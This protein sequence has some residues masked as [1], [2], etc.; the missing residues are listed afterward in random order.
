[1]FRAPYHHQRSVDRPVRHHR[2]EKRKIVTRELPET[3]LPVRQNPSI[4]LD[5]RANRGNQRPVGARARE[6]Q[7]IARLATGFFRNRQSQRDPPVR[8]ASNAGGRARQ[9][10][11]KAK[12]FRQNVCSSRWQHGQR[13][14][15]ASQ[16]VH[17]FVH[18]AVSAADD[19]EL[20][21]LAH[22]S[23]RKNGRFARRRRLLEFGL[24]S[25][26]AKNSP[27]LVQL[28]HTPAAARSGVHD[29]YGVAQL[30]GHSVHSIQIK[31]T[32]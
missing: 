14:L 20:P 32:E 3:F 18:G 28:R 6:A 1:M 23:P 22:G 29:Q 2:P 26:L 30:R 16:S 5:L 31:N 11:G 17:R 10:P 27:R 8:R 9:I 4:Q 13:H 12:F 24:D 7:E 15:A 25:R 19:G 21:R